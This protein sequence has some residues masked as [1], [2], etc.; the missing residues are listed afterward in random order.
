MKIHGVI[1]ISILLANIMGIVPKGQLNA[2]ANKTVAASINT[3]GNLAGGFNSMISADGRYV[4]FDSL[5]T[6]MVAGDTNNAYDVF[7]RDLQAKTTK[8]ISVD[9]FGNQANGASN[10]PYISATGRFVAYVSSASNLVPNDTNGL[11]DIFLY[12][13]QTQFTV[14]VSISSQGVQTNNFYTTMPTVSA[15]GR[16][17]AFISMASNLV[18]GDEDEDTDVFV[19]DIQSQTTICASVDLNGKPIISGAAEISANGRFVAYHDVNHRVVVFDLQTKTSEI[20]SVASDGTL[21][22]IGSA[23]DDPTMSADG[24][25]VVFISDANNLVPPDTLNNSGMYIHDRLTHTTQAITFDPMQGDSV[26]P[27]VSADGR[28]IVFVQRYGD[29]YTYRYDTW[30]KKVEGV[31]VM[32]SGYLSYRPSYSPSISD[33]GKFVAF[34]S[35]DNS[36]VEGDTFPGEDVFVREMMIYP[37]SEIRPCMFFP[38][39]SR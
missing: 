24:R 16:Y 31:P 2:S 19:R 10:V 36:L 6:N 37:C 12:D 27:R 38:I 15:D 29:L 13:N 25:Y 34:T 30:L 9:S 17:V 1:L 4:A 21:P 26:G 33:D 35:D 7:L 11:Q 18:A 39:I 3:N 8:R 32:L 23:S 28:F 22:N 5:S 20:V 14:L